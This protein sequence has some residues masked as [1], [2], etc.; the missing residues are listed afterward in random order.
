M[1]SRTAVD[2]ALLQ[3]FQAVAEETRFRIVQ[4]LAEGERCVCEL[5]DELDAAQS[6]LSF[7]LRKLKD[8]GVVADRRDGRWVYYSLVP[9]SLE[10]MRGFLGEVKPAERWRDGAGGETCCG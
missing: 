6:R 2:D 1:A 7:H 4:L 10:A 8:A 5:Q 3:R 9:E